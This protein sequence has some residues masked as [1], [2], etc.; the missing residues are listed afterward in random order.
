MSHIVSC[1]A[2]S[3]LLGVTAALSGCA[4]TL[5]P[6]HDALKARYDESLIEIDNPRTE[7]RIVSPGAVLDHTEGPDRP[8][9]SPSSP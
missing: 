3:L 6:V 1:V 5:D 7:G 4:S 9:T 2:L 8:C